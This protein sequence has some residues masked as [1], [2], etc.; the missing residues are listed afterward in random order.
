MPKGNRPVLTTARLALR[1]FSGIHE[2]LGDPLIPF[3]G[4]LTRPSSPLPE[5]LVWVGFLQICHCCRVLT[6]HIMQLLHL[7]NEIQIINKG[8]A[9]RNMRSNSAIYRVGRD[10]FT[11][12]QKH[13]SVTT[14]VLL[15]SLMFSG[16]SSPHV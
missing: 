2:G 16:R 6:P 3:P 11:G 10:F 7:Q 8:N 12:L 1:R 15:C 14:G 4:R 5:H 9:S 13:V